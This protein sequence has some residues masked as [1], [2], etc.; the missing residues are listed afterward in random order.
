MVPSQRGAGGGHP[1][2]PRVSCPRTRTGCPR[3]CRS[4][5]GLPRSCPRWCCTSLRGRTRECCSEGQL[6]GSGLGGARGPP[7]AAGR[8]RATEPPAVA[9]KQSVA[10]VP[11]RNPSAAPP[12][13]E[14]VCLLRRSARSRGAGQPC[15][16][17]RGETPRSPGER[18]SGRGQAATHDR[19]RQGCCNRCSP[20]PC[21]SRTAP[22]SG[23]G[24]Q[25]SCRSTSGQWGG[26]SST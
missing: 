2:T 14:Q 9:T 12:M 7:A 19:R 16:S 24:S 23:P 21:C 1:G 15:P 11:L 22:Q 8:G 18:G 5:S 26:S 25:G 17:R 6:P 10:Q 3:R 4:W 20:R 13:P